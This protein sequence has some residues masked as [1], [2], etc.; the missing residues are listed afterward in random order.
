MGRVFYNTRFS[1][2]LGENRAI[3]DIIVRNVPDGPVPSPTPTPTLTRTPTPTPSITPTRTVTPTITPTRTLTPTVTPT[4]TNYP[5]CPEEF[6]ITNSTGGN[7][8]DGTYDRKY[9]YSGGSMNYGYYTG[10]QY[11]V[12]TAPDGYNYPVFN[13]GNRYIFRRVSAL[14]VDAG[15]VTGI[16]TSDPWSTTGYS[17]LLIPGYTQTITQ[18]DVRWLQG[19][20]NTAPG[21][22][23]YLN[24]PPTCPTTTPTPSV[25]STVTPTIT[26]TPSVT[27]TITPTKTATPTPTVTPSSSP[28]PPFDS[29][30]AAYLAAVISAGGTTNSTISGATNTLFTDLKSS[31]L[32]SKFIAFYPI[33]G[34]VQ[35]S[36]AING[37]LN[38]TYNISYSGSWTHSSLGQIPPNGGGA[39]LMNHIIDAGSAAGQVRNI[40]QGVYLNTNTNSYGSGYEID[41]GVRDGGVIWRLYAQWTAENNSGAYFGEGSGAA[42]VTPPKGVGMYVS[43]R[44][45]NTGKLFHNGALQ[46]TGGGTFNVTSTYSLSLGG[47]YNGS[48]N[49]FP[50]S[51]R[52]AFAFVGAYLSDSEV[53][54]LSTIINNFETTLG[55]N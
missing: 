55:R 46:A 2:Y 21:N 19:G 17:A 53:T 35:A 18:G 49:Q 42:L 15:W 20:L 31:G 32:Y 37:N 28:P 23:F 25:T 9:S 8:F 11:L 48:S 52:Q 27:P 1:N 29:D 41:L 51:K 40:S 26:T 16:I 36:H 22:S 34:G 10:S 30:A 13:E 44:T 33:L 5:I 54:I 4:Q 14:G 7:D 45:S 43:T 38:A 24:Y 50:S 6:I 12:G 3:L 39:G 47:E